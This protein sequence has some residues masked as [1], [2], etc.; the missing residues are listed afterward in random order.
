MREA[1]RKLAGYRITN[2]VIKLIE[3]YN[4]TRHSPI[5]ATSDEAWNSNDS[6][7]LKLRNS[8]ASAYSKIFKK[9]IS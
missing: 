6:L 7:E 1:F 9:T 2:E 8:K 4:A 5:G 3:K